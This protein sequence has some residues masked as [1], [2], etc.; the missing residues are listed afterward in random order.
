MALTDP[1]AALKSQRLPLASVEGTLF[2]IS[3]QKFSDPIYWSRRGLYRFD[4]PLAKYGVLYTGRTCETALLEVFG[5]SWIKSRMTAL[6]FLK[7]FD[8][9]EIALSHRLKVVNLSGK[10]LNPLGIDAN[11]FASLA[12]DVTQRWAAAFMEHPDAPLGIRYPSRK[13][14]RLHNFALFST[15][16]ALAAVTI[17]HRFP[18]LDHPH[19]F[20]LLQSYRVALI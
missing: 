20:R 13:N 5:D 6:S 17:S 9:C 12:Y 2:R 10:R 19:L 11:I 8:V 14:E 4:S 1:P 18:L 3:H 15:P 7:E 16:G